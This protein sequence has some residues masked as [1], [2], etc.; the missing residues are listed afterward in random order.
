MVVTRKYLVSEKNGNEKD[1]DLSRVFEK[2]MVRSC[3]Q[4]QENTRDNAELYIK[5]IMYK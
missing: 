4:K 2:E 5:H 3:I 1:E